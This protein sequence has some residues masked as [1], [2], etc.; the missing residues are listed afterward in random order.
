MAELVQS[1]SQS[2]AGTGSRSLSLFENAILVVSASAFLA[3][4]AHASFVL[5]FTPVPITLQN[6]GVLLIAFLLGPHRAAI[7]CML[8]L[9]EGASGMPV[10]APGPGGVAQLLGPSGGFLF[11]YPAVAYVAGLLFRWRSTLV[12]TV[13]AGVAAEVL[14]FVSG[15]SWFMLLTPGT[16]VMKALTLTVVPFLAGE[17]LKVAAVSAIAVRA[18]KVFAL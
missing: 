13:L 5:P 14:L 4:C 16:G 2:L 9:L 12:F 10:F 7:A 3:L 11:S 1:R 18:K 17:V 6:F 15:A 8:Y